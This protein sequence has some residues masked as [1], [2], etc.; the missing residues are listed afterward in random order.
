MRKLHNTAD[1]SIQAYNGL[2]AS[3]QLGREKEIVLK[4]IAADQP[5]TSKMLAKATGL[6]RGNVTCALNQM[7]FVDEIIKI[8][9]KKPCPITG[10]TASHYV[11]NNWVEIN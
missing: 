4:A 8:V 6:E 5:C 7:T 9:Y 2:N 1:T 11:L 10:H 3:G